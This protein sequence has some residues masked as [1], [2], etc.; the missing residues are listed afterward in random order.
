MHLLKVTELNF[1]VLLS[2]EL[3]EM[4]EVF[5]PHNNLPA[6]DV[7]RISG[8]LNLPK[9]SSLTITSYLDKEE[10][11]DIDCPVYKKLLSL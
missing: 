4:A 6:L 10:E 1:A 7:Y 11:Q 5:A 2:N 3:S 9:T 8:N